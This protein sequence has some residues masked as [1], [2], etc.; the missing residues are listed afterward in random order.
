[1]VINKLKYVNET[2][3]GLPKIG[4]KS[5][6]TTSSHLKLDTPLLVDLFLVSIVLT[7]FRQMDYYKI[8]VKVKK[9]IGMLYG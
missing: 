9:S 3:F 6:F 4:I 5:Y 7:I 8:V 2:W 1:M